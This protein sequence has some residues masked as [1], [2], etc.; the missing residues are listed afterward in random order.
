M[1]AGQ[2]TSTRPH[3][4]DEMGIHNDCGDVWIAREHY[5][6]R[7]DARR[8]YMDFAGCHFLDA[9]VLSRWMRWTPDDP[10]AA[11]YDGEYWTECGSDEPGAFRV[12]RCE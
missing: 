12:W 10:G 11:E 3:L 8:W 6:T 9:R 2:A 4:P 5:P 1:N 7:A